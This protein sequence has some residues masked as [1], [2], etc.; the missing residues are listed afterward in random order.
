MM[1]IAISNN[2]NNTRIT[3]NY[4][5]FSREFFS[6]SMIFLEFLFVNKNNFQ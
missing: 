4:N 3:Y 5:F 2:I 1:S 6:A